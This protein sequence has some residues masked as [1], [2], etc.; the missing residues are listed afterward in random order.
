LGRGDLAGLAVRGGQGGSS[1]RGR[2]RAGEGPERGSYVAAILDDVRKL[3]QSH[4]VSSVVVWCSVYTDWL[5]R[6]AV[7]GSPRSR[8]KNTAGPGRPP[9]PAVFFLRSPPLFTGGRRRRSLRGRRTRRGARRAARPARSAPA[10][11]QSTPG[12]AGAGR[13]GR[14]T[15]AAGP[16]PT[17]GERRGGP[18]GAAGAAPGRRTSRRAARSRAGRRAPRGAAGA[19]GGGAAATAE[20][21]R[22]WCGSV[23]VGTAGR[24]SGGKKVV[25]CPGQVG[26]LRVTWR[27]RAMVWPDRRSE[28]GRPGESV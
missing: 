16:A 3:C 11:L 17:A 27:G 10:A 9:G 13:A 4:S 26:G 15:A 23:G 21:T 6:A 25:V 18:R 22:A 28:G 2:T 7:S 5:E 12:G 20:R 24:P 19:S 8:R 14:G 1:T